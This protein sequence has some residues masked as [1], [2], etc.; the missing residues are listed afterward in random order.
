[1]NRLDAL[2]RCRPVDRPL[3]QSCTSG[4]MARGRIALGIVAWLAASGCH[5]HSFAPAPAPSRAHWSAPAPIHDG[6]G[7]FFVGNSFFGWQGRSLPDW[8]T[9]LGQAVSP[10]I[11]IVTGSDIV[12][13]NHPLAE[14][15]DHAATREAL[16]ARKYRV[17]VLQAEEFEAVDH[18]ARFQQSVRD[19]NRAVVAAGGRTILFMTWDFPWRPFIEKVAA[20]YDEIGRELGIPVI[21]VGLI[22]RDCGERPYAPGMPPHWLL[23]DAEHPKGDLHEN[24][25]G[26]ALDAYATFEMLTGINPQGR[27][28]TA[29]GNSND[30]AIMKYLSGMSWA[31]VEPRLRADTPAVR[32]SAIA[33]PAPSL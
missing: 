13:G 30:D 16:A 20:S 5:R 28:F 32:V 6:D 7:V 31:R 1:L 23:A 12:F 3:A 19:F 4:L 11:R 14:F 2:V 22:Y 9:A 17:F 8:V 21:P 26:A 25:K 10:P 29:P 33:S 18:K 24:E 15:L 27:N